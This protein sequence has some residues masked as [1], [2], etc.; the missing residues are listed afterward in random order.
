[1]AR[2]CQA[3]LDS[4]APCYVEDCSRCRSYLRRLSSPARRGTPRAGARSSPARPRR[5]ASPP[6]RPQSP[7]A[8]VWGASGCSCLDEGSVPGRSGSDDDSRAEAGSDCTQGVGAEADD[9]VEPY[10]YS[11]HH[12]STLPALHHRRRGRMPPLTT[13]CSSA[14]I[15]YPTWPTGN[16][17][18]R[19]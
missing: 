2:H 9:D 1:M 15:A 7:P 11:L 18:R 16:V 13:A 19:R 12:L 10:Y 6:A 5:T 3:G 4:V 17:S 14:E 8:P